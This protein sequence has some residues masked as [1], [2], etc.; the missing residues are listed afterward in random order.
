MMKIAFLALCLLLS[1]GSQAQ[2][3]IETPTQ[4]QPTAFAI[5]IDNA[6][7]RATRNAVMQYRDAVQQDGLAA[8]IVRGDWKNPDEVKTDIAKVYRQAPALEGI[9]LVGDIPV[10]MIRNAQHMTTAFKMN[11]TTFP[12]P[13]SSVPS[14][15]VYDDLHLKFKFIR[16][17]LANRQFII[18]MMEAC[19]YHHK[20]AEMRK[21][22]TVYVT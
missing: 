16:L 17:L 10:A 9:V 2:T 6:T 7:Y 22:E 21:E 14:D 18:R 3:V 15:R 4:T 8:Y 5:V 12:F 11:E 20:P 13:Q 19:A 1:V